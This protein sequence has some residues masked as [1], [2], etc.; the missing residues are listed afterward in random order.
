MCTFP[1]FLLLVWYLFVCCH[2]FDVVHAL[3]HGPGLR[4]LGCVERSFGLGLDLDVGLD[5]AIWFGPSFGI[6]RV[7]AFVVAM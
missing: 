4:V 2:G 6:C 5:L 1:G 7:F 3:G